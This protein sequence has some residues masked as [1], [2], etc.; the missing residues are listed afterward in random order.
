MMVGKVNG[1]FGTF[2]GDVKFDAA[3][4]AAS[5]FDVAITVDSIN[6]RNDARDVHLK[7]ADFFDAQKYPQ[8]LFK[9]K[10]GGQT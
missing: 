4:V 7:G 1:V 9:S 2:T 5:K 3:D 10:N 6:T 8:I